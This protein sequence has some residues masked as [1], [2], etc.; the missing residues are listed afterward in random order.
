MPTNTA[1]WLEDIYGASYMTPIKNWS[2]F[3][4]KTRIVFHNERTYR[5]YFHKR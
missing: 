4:Q 3:D 2:E 5:R 1:Q